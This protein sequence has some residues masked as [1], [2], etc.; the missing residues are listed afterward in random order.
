MPGD[1]HAGGH[2][3]RGGDGRQG[4]PDGPVPPQPPHRGRPPN[5]PGERDRKR[6]RPQPDQPG[7][8]GHRPPRRRDVD[9]QADD[10]SQAE[11]REQGVDHRLLDAGRRLRRRAGRRRGRPAAGD[12]PNEPG[13]VGQLVPQVAAELDG[14][15]RAGHRQQHVS[16]EP[17]AGRGAEPGGGQPVDRPQVDFTRLVHA[18]QPGG[19]EP[20]GPQQGV[21]PDPLAQP[22]RVRQLHP[23]PGER[24]AEVAEAEE[25]AVGQ[26]GQEG[27]DDGVPGDRLGGRG[28]HQP[29]G[30]QRR[31]DHRPETR[32]Q[33]VFGRRDLAGEQGVEPFPV[34]GRR[35]AGGGRQPPGGRQPA[36]VGRQRGGR[37]R[38]GQRPAAERGDVP[39]RVQPGRVGGPVPGDLLQLP[40][41][42]GGRRPGVGRRRVDQGHD[43][44]GPRP[45]VVGVPPERLAEPVN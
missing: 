9:Q 20:V 5:L 38:A 8:G 7:G 34:A 39:G 21:A 14:Q 37:Q 41:R 1:R 23:V 45:A 32:F 24:V 22:G 40:Q 4:R 36:D 6:H 35:A 27:G 33:P 25:P 11:R 44:R 16:A 10:G 43:G 2:Q 12:P 28:R 15:E 17:P 42:P 29:G 3:R 19:Q 13:Q 31:G 26:A 18:A 30:V